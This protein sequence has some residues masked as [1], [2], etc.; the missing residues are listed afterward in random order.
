MGKLLIRQS[1]CR[2]TVADPCL[3]S[4]L[5][6]K[7]KGNCC[8]L[9]FSFFHKT[10]KARKRANCCVAS[11]AP[12]AFLSSSPSD[13]LSE[14]LNDPNTSWKKLLLFRRVRR[15]QA[16]VRAEQNQTSPAPI[17]WHQVRPC[18]AMYTAEPAGPL[19]PRQSGLCPTQLFID[20]PLCELR[21]PE[22]P[23]AG[24]NS[25]VTD[26]SLLSV[27]A[28]GFVLVPGSLLPPLTES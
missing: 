13:L 10:L 24:C 4:S 19:V 26:Y 7:K 8:L 20:T 5:K 21:R 27:F 25:K 18:A 11:T 14:V 17:C 28:D 1:S 12:W 9:L 22:N 2:C 15:T 6:K 23:S 3:I 16:V